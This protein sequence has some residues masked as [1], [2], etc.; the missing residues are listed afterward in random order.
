MSSYSTSDGAA[1]ITITFKL[2]TDLDKAQVLV[3]NR[4]QSP[5]RACRKRCGGWRDHA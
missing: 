3:Q 2:G 1:S 5:R 4:V